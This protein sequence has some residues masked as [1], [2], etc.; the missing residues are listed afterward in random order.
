[1]KKKVIWALFLVVWLLAFSTVFSHWTEE[2]MIP[3]VLSAQSTLYRGTMKLCLSLDSIFIQDNDEFSLFR[4]S[5]GSGWEAGPHAFL[6]EPGSYFIDTEQTHRVIVYDYGPFIAASTKLPQSGQPVLVVKNP[7]RREDLLLAVSRSG[8]ANLREDSD[9]RHLEA[10]SDTAAL[11]TLRDAYSP[12]SENVGRFMLFDLDLSSDFQKHIYSLT[13]VKRFFTCI[14]WIGAVIA[15]LLITLLLWG[16]SYRLLK[17]EK[18]NHPLLLINA[19][20][21]AL[22]LALLPV[23]LKGADLPPSLLPGR[24]VVDIPHYVNQHREICAALSELISQ[25]PIAGE[26]LSYIRAM[27]GLTAGI[28]LAGITAAILLCTLERRQLKTTRYVPK[29]RA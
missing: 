19:A 3:R 24:A 8:F 4:I 23:F 20:V 17:C 10:K 16:H 11:I 5:E 21:C 2:L 6:A 26:T 18:K 7:E 12:F 9:L 15:S 1:M 22:L 29:H 28:V 13:D 25:S 14:P 27:T